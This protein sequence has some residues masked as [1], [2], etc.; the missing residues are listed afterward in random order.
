MKPTLPSSAGVA[1]TPQ[2]VEHISAVCLQ[3]DDAV[4]R[5]RATADSLNVA[6]STLRRDLADLVIVLARDGYVLSDSVREA[7]GGAFAEQPLFEAAV[8]MGWL[9]QPDRGDLSHKETRAGIGVVEDIDRCVL[10]GRL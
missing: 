6:W 2:R 8:R 10:G 1:A 3:I 4:I 5:A 9:E 7:L